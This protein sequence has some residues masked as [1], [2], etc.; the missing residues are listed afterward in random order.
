MNGVPSDL[1]ITIV[2]AVA[3]N[4]ALGFRNAIPWRAPSD[5]KRFKEITW[6]RPLIMGRKTFESIGKPLPGRETVVVTRDPNFFGGEPPARAHLA[7]DFES[8][9]ALANDIGRSLH[10]A[11][12]IVAGGAAFF[13]RALPLARFLRLT[14]VD[15][16]PQA[17][18][19]FPD[20]DWR[21]WT[22][23]RRETPPRGEKDEA[24][25]EYV[26]YRR[27]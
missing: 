19:F 18:V 10:C 2:A 4:G 14:R 1:P 26:D 12:I 22:E 25:L 5:L 6:G 9:V 24:D 27:V 23:L 7:G 21:Q 15:C 13:R 3:R 11:E 17:D 20:V 8:A 16:E